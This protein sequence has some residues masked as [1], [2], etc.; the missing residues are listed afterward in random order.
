MKKTISLLLVLVLCLSLCACG[1]ANDTPDTTEATNAPTSTQ[2]VSN[3]EDTTVEDETTI[4]TESITISHPLVEEFCGEWK[5]NMDEAPFES[6]FINA[7]GTCVVDGVDAVWQIEDFYTKDDALSVYVFVN[8]E[9]YCGILYF[10]NTGA[11]TLTKP[12]GNGDM[13]LFLPYEAYK[14]Q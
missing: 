14:E 8:G 4:S 11:S 3:M 2:N 9:A 12:Y 10:S 1:G 13:P 6:L 7:D 5:T